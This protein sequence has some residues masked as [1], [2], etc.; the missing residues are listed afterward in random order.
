[1]STGR[2][3]VVVVGGGLAGLVAAYRLSQGPA[4][5]PGTDGARASHDGGIAPPVVTLIEAGT[6]LGG[7]IDA[8]EVDGPPVEAGPDSFVVRKPEAVELCRELG[9]GSQLIQPGATGAFVIARGKLLPYPP[10]SAFGVPSDAES[11][12]RWPGL[13]ARGRLRAVTDLWRPARPPEGDESIGSLLTR[14]LGDECA[15]VLVGPLLAGIN[16][17]DPDRLSVRSTFPELADWERLYGSLIRGSRAARRARTR[18]VARTDGDGGETRAPGQA[19][20]TPTGLF[21][22][23]EGGL[24]TLVDALHQAIGDERIRLSTAASSVE[25]D[26]HA[27]KWRIGLRGSAETIDADGMV[28]ATP[29]FVSADLLRARAADMAADLDAIL[30]GST[31][32]VA[33]AYPPGTGDTLPGGSGFIVP[34]GAV[35]GGRSLSITACTW[36]SRKWPDARYGDRAVVRAFVGRAGDEAILEGTDPELVATVVHDLDAVVPLGAA[37]EAAAMARWPRSMPQYE[38]GHAERLRRIVARVESLPGLALA[39][40]AYGGVGIADVVR[41]AGEA[42]ER[43]FGHL[44][45]AEDAAATMAGYALE[46]KDG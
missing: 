30:Y 45:R 22:S 23:L 12:L 33:L 43:V 37:P 38:V 46:G 17:G 41:G 27:G 9:L 25:L 1:V 16:S 13:S 15:R 6:R 36:V 5:L 3:H 34:P 21:S 11:I 26:R 44:R 20:A 2:R 8:V 4:D 28:L 29:A 18:L 39:G 19:E 35:M 31:A 42:A 10:D 14:R 7:V 24:S 32:V 40:S